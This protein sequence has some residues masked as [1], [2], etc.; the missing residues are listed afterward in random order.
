MSRAPEAV[1]PEPLG[2]GPS[3]IESSRGGP[4][5]PGDA[6][7][8]SLEPDDRAAR[9]RRGL[10]LA[11]ALV[12]GAL[13]FWAVVV[14]VALLVIVQH[15]S[16]GLPSV[17]R[18][19]SGYHPPQVSRIFA[20]DGIKDDPATPGVDEGYPGTLLSS[21]FTERRTVVA[22]SEIPNAAKLAFLAA[23]DAR[24]YE[25]E[26]LN[27]LG[28]LRAMWAN[29]RAGRTVQG[30]STI[31]QQVVKNILLDRERT[32]RRKVRETIL[33]RR[34][35]QH[36][37]K[38]EIFGLYLNHIYLGHGRYGIE[39]A[40]RYYFGKHAAQLD[41][42][43][44]SLLAGLVASPERFSPRK[45]PERALSRRKY[46]LEQ[47]LA[48]GFVTREFFDTLTA[49]PLHLAPEV[50]TQSGLCP[51]AVEVAKE[52]LAVAQKGGTS[53][54]GYSVTTTIQPEL[55]VAA[56]RAVR[57]L[58]SDYADRH[59]LWPPYDSKA[60][61]SWGK[62]WQGKPSPHRVY[63][64]T[65]QS[66]D[67]QTGQIVVQVGDVAGRVTLAD[68]ERYNPKHLPPSQFAAVGAVLRVR[69]LDAPDADH[70]P[71]LR[72]ELGP[73]AALVAVDVRSRDIVALVG[74]HEALPGTL[75]RAR[76]ARRQP[77]SSFKPIVFS[78]ALRTHLVT[79]GSVLDLEHKGRGV[80]AE[81]PFR[82]SVRN[83]LAQSNNEAAVQLLRKSGPQQVV[84]WAAQLGIE[85]KLGADLSLALGSYEVTPL[86]M[87]NAFA[88][89]ASG[90]YFEPPRL[91]AALSAPNGDP[92]PLPERGER[93]R[94]MSAEE[95]YLITSLLE[96]VVKTG[97]ARQALGIGHPVAAK[98]GTTNEVKDAWLVGYT[99]ELSAA[100]WVGF[101]DTLPLGQQ[102]SGS[103]TALPAFVDFMKAA[104]EG[105]PHSEFPRPPGIVVVNID[106]ETGLL[107]RPGQANVTAEEFL[108]G[109]VP[110]HSAP[111]P[112][113][114][115]LTEM[116]YK[117]EPSDPHELPP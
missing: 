8:L 107:P 115:K 31:T 73:Q 47:M 3:G 12:A 89:F 38:D 42:A 111:E 116:P 99:T 37:T 29:L 23:E 40:S 82:I 30:G 71:R 16:E 58:L 9:W 103:R 35:E 77:G 14:G 92:L 10:L 97:T 17:E 112:V 76:H 24:F 63:V 94:V 5:R 45:V 85:S 72:L 13:A 15:Y 66:T 95:A 1:P 90:G 109:T 64:G 101:D 62:P 19:K 11:L 84:D 2:E 70:Q 55:Q 113:P 104:H 50:D 75:D 80:T 56:R 117:P 46:V 34:L 91:L 39:E 41:G 108:E 98:T 81:P 68:E 53:Q 61:K 25:H 20:A 102:E 28:V 65:V 93:R 105:R 110:E 51:E 22:F 69:F 106:P 26:G 7:G 83:A 59:D 57:K 54:G 114:D 48:K 74:S 18:L 44:A 88:T 6:S 78:Q 60:I 36:L 79:A 52:A 4:K 43:E 67:D 96:S 33:S 87:A 49:A 27:Y 100:V 21:V 86:E 32:Y